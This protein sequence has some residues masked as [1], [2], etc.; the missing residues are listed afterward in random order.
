MGV[1]VEELRTFYQRFF[2]QREGEWLVRQDEALREAV[3]GFLA[4]FG[5][6]R[7]VGME[8]WLLQVL[9]EQLNGY[10]VMVMSAEDF[11]HVGGPI[12]LGGGH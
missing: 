7:A 5:L 1:T 8:R 4:R 9:V 2:A 12:L 6:D 3:T 10:D 11:R